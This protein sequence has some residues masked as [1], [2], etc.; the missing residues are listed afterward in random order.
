ML[1]EV[2]YMLRSWDIMA[3]IQYHGVPN[4]M[5]QKTVPNPVPNPVFFMFHVFT[6]FQSTLT[7]LL[8]ATTSSHRSNDGW[9]KRRRNGVTG[10]AKWKWQLQFGCSTTLADEVELSLQKLDTWANW[11]CTKCTADG[12]HWLA[13]EVEPSPSTGVVNFTTPQPV[14][15]AGLCNLLRSVFKLFKLGRSAS[16][17]LS[18]VVLRSNISPR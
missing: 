4:P 1:K 16:I 8:Q 6:S 13:G 5:Y 7:C 9:S 3:K 2:C 11:C 15:R 18:K 12:V 10:S 17:D 14:W